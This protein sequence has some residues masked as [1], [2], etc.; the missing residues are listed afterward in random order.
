M[1]RW[2]PW[3]LMAAALFAMAVPAGAA[4]DWDAARAAYRSKDYP[5]AVALLRPLADDGD[6]RARRLLGALHRDGRGVEPDPAR[7]AALFRAAAEQGDARGQANLAEAL[8]SGRGVPRDRAA[9]AR[10]FDAAAA[11]G[12]VEAQRRLA[13]MHLQGVGVAQDEAAAMR[14]LLAWADHDPE[15]I[16]S[17]LEDLE[18]HA[19]DA[20]AKGVV[21]AQNAVGLR[22]LTGNG[23]AVDDAQAVAW[24]RRAAGAGHTDAQLN[25]G[26]VH[27]KGRGVA[28][29]D[30][31]GLRWTRMAAAAGNE[32]AQ[33]N[34]ALM[35][36]RGEGVARD[37][38]QSFA[39]ASVAAQAG[40]QNAKRL[41][42]GTLREQMTAADLVEG[43]RRVAAITAEQRQAGRL[44]PRSGGAAPPAKS[45]QA[46]TAAATAATPNPPAAAA[47]PGGVLSRR[48]SASGFAVSRTHIVTSQ[49]NITPCRE[50]RSPRLGTLEVAREDAGIGLA[51]LASAGRDGATARLRDG[52][53]IRP[54]D[55]V[56][57]VG[58][59]LT[60]FLGDNPSVSTGTVSALNGLQGDTRFLTFSAPLAQGGSGGPIV[61]SAGQVVGVAA[62]SMNPALAM[63]IGVSPQ[64]INLAV[65]VESLKAFLDA[66]NVGYDTERPAA[67]RSP[68]DV[69]AAATA[70]T[71]AVECWN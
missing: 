41:L 1:S 67:A 28:A 6:P 10:W 38:A 37:L 63:M 59:P 61:D 44:S 3:A 12:D 20:V 69:A 8:F 29:D 26:Y 27:L 4:A 31:E 24:F 57:A 49:R 17:G 51:L 21:N 32:K 40:Q 47:E 19:I 15:T 36:Q 46:F 64:S 9:A 50:L 23:V 54:G 66:A 34:L 7:A 68:A 48:H 25:M 43:L 42:G 14:W 30:A 55:A 62:S 39:W 5:A 53:G 18:P 45:T 33:Y 22:Y 60:D 11:Q 52:D 65:N 71:V 70:F 2:R 56:V 13:Q 16:R 35:Y 58:Y